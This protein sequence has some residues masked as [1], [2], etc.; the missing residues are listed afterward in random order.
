MVV[1]GGG[2]GGGS[3]CLGSVL[4]LDSPIYILVI[5]KCDES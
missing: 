2:G 4:Q 3:F 1:A 5:L